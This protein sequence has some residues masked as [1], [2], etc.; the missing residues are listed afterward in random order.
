VEGF[1]NGRLLFA[2]NFAKHPAMLGSLIPSSRILVERL[3]G[4]ADWP[5]AQTV[6][7]YGPGVGT[8]TA[9]ILRR[10]P[11]AGHLIAIET[12]GDFVEYLRAEL[13]DPRLQVV[14]GSAADIAAILQRQGLTGADYVLSG[15]PFSVMPD[16]L[17]RDIL[18]QTRSVLRPEGAFLVYQFSSKVLSDLK[19]TFS[20][21]ERGYVL[22]NVLPAHWF[23]CRA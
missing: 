11:P 23:D 20:R 4:R 15:I 22:R 2:R 14:H 5:R 8:F 6:V 12:N 7:E 19:R 10:L 18:E 21:I 16:E 17:R 1:G 9:E 3:L 13:P